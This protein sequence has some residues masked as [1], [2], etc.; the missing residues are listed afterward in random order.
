MKQLDPKEILKHKDVDLAVA[1]LRKSAAV[2]NGVKL[3]SAN[4]KHKPLSRKDPAKAN[5]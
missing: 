1:S 4:G 5:R 2:A 3:F